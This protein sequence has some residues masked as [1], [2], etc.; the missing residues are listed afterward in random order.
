MAGCLFTLSSPA[1]RIIMIRQNPLTPASHILPFLI[2]V[3]NYISSSHGPGC[4][5]F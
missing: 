5:T 2:L 1:M 4:P 3:T